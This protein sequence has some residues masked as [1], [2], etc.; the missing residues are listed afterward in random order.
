MKVVEEVMFNYCIVAIVVDVAC[1]IINYFGDV[2]AAIVVVFVGE[3]ARR[4]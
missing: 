1:S 4:D 2:K 3:W